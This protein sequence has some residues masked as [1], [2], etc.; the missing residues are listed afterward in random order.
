MSVAAVLLDQVS[1]VPAF[2]SLPFRPKARRFQLASKAMH[3][4]ARTVAEDKKKREARVGKNIVNYDD[5]RKAEEKM[6]LNELQ[7][8]T[9]TLLSMA[10]S[11]G[12]DH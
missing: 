11:L 8:D 1:W 4:D 9:W 3:G 12:K 7:V 5:G 2:Q 6:K 10:T